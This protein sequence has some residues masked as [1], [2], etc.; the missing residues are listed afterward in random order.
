[1]SAIYPSRPCRDSFDHP[2]AFAALLWHSWNFRLPP[3]RQGWFHPTG[4]VQV[5][6]AVQTQTNKEVVFTEEVTPLIAKQ[7]PLVWIVFW[8]VTPGWHYWRSSPTALAKKSSPISVGSPSCQ[9]TVISEASCPS[10][11]WRI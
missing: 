4:V 3:H 7:V 1:V 8:R 9:A 11:S 6:R 2:W 5:A 10:I